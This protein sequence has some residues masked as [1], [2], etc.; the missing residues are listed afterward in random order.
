MGS[1]RVGEVERK[2]AETEIRL[3]L[4]L[5]GAGRAKV[6]TGVPFFDHMLT[7]VA[8]HGLFNLEIEARG[9][10]EVDYHHTVEDVGIV[11][12]EAVAR[13]VGEKGGLR[14]YG[15]CLLP[16]DEALAQ[17]ALDLG[18]RPYCV[19]R[20]E[21]RELRVRDFNLSLMREFFGAFAN[22]ARANVHVRILYGIEP[23]HLAEAM[24][25]GFGRAL[26]MATQV[27]LRLGG[28]LPSTKGLL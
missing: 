13:A 22:A 1:E 8:R 24:C 11:L 2:T 16:M 20:V 25:K 7:L 6:D 21:D 14:R 3:R 12:G 19:Y 5:D 18:G 10:L 27:D 26:D 9:D 23:H 15:W 17:V 4:V 28:E